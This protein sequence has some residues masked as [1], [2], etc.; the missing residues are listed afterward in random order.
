MDE[1]MQVVKKTF[2]RKQLDAMSVDDLAIIIGDAG[3]GARFKGKA[4]V[5]RADGSIKYDED[6]VPGE[7]N[8]T[9]EELAM[10]GKNS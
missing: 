1:R 4:I 10:N 9:P 8:E 2:S 7:F 6:A 5:K 3:A